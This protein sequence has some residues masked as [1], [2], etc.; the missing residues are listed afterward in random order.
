MTAIFSSRHHLLAI[1]ETGN[2]PQVPEL[3]SRVDG[4]ARCQFLTFSNNQ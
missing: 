3:V 1:L 2:N 4:E